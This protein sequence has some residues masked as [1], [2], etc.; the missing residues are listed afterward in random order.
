MALDAVSCGEAEN[1]VAPFFSVHKR[2]TDDV[3]HFYGKKVFKGLK[4]THLYVFNMGA[5]HYFDG[6]RTNG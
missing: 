4:F 1:M 6:V 3:V 5:M 2:R